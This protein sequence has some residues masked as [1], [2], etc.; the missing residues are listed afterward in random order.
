VRFGPYRLDLVDARLWKGSEPVALQPKPLAVLGYLAAR[1]GMVVG[2]DE[3]I[4]TL[5]A[6]TFVTK[7]VLKVAVRAI[8]E[9][10]GDDAGAPRYVETVGREGYRF[11]GGGAV[12]PSR[13]VRRDTP[14]I[15]APRMVGR[16][17]ELDE[18]GALLRQALAGERTTVFVTGEAG[19]GKTTLIDRFVEEVARE[20]GVSVGRGQCLEQYGEGEAYLPVL[21]ALGGLLRADPEGELARVLRQC[22]PTWTP[23]LPVLETPGAVA[24]DDGPAVAPRPARML[25]EL[26]D[27]LD[28]FTRERPLVFVL[29]DLQWSDPSTV[30]LIARVASRRAPAR[31]LMIGTFRPADVI[32]HD[33][34]LHAV[35]QDLVA[36]GFC[37]VLRLELLSLAEVGAYVDA[38][39]GIRS[40]DDTRRIATFVHDHSEGNALFMVN[41][42][43]D[44]V[45][46]GVLVR[47]DGEWRVEGALDRATE[48]IP[49]GLH[50]LLARRMRRLSRSARRVLDA[51]SVVGDEFA[52][53]AVAA[54]LGDPPDTVEDACEALAAQGAIIAENG[55]AEWP[56]GSLSGRYRFLHALYRRVLYDEV[57]E[58]RR[59]RF[60]RAIGL[61]EEAGF[62]GHVVERAPQLAMHFERGRDH[63]RALEYHTLSGRVALERHA[64]HEAVAHFTAALDAL[65]RLPDG[66]ER[67]ERELTLVV[68]I[69]TMLMAIRGYASSDTER[70][71]ARA[72]ALCDA[73]P[74][75]PSLSAVL[76]GLVSYHQVR[77]EFAEAHT[78]GE[79]LLERAAE[80][81]HDRAL[82]V[83]ARY[84]HGTT[85]FHMGRLDAA[86]THLE[87]ALGDYD[88]AAYRE[89]VTVYGGYDPGVAC[90]LWLAW[91]LELQ[92]RLDEAARHNRRGVELARRHGDVFTLAW[93]HYAA[94]V[95]EGMF[96]QWAA[97]ERS[98]TEAAALAEEHGFP[99]VL[100]MALANRGWALVMLGQPDPGIRLVR[101]GV[102]AVEETGARLLGPM[103]LAMLA[104]VDA[105]AGDRAAAARRYDEALDAVERSGERLHEAPVLIAK[106]QALALGRVSASG[107]ETAESCLLRALAVAAEQGASLVELRAAVVLARHYRSRGRAGEGR[108]L[109][110]AAHACFAGAHPGAP[111]I[112]AARRLLGEE[113]S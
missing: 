16:E 103:Y 2:R 57:S 17:R 15:P 88:P 51:A 106:G 63:A 48:W 37:E 60:H 25:R 89:H 30:D 5:W 104:A 21:E 47:R 3:L 1:P 55:I 99:Y 44:L 83:Q 81:P 78:L 18:L 95:T 53:A 31:L 96:G 80:T 79:L 72:R 11:I 113:P 7:A 13:R 20:P 56:D 85:L 108:A 76:R 94:G 92:G 111:E 43:N 100:G 38:R 65:G 73:M 32:V 68:S 42:V 12:G 62:G 91:T 10:L 9:A 86:R 36:N 61:R 102:A 71:F 45:A 24:P 109:V 41:V 28:L 58:A 14:A 34:H 64:A 35:E 97:A 6:G 93:A 59:I 69:A 112:V 39:L 110:E 98:S 101:E 82:R 26:A 23:L 90:S 107:A 19:I 84:G 66:P 29:E 77:A 8:R 54:A 75:S 52:V 33:H 49:T 22:A 105:M 4:R 67:G 46:R 74:E 27:A 40:E 50:E 87:A 70:A